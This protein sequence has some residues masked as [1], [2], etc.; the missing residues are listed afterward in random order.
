MG[1][2]D[3]RIFSR[4]DQFF[5]EWVGFELLRSPEDV[6][7]SARS[8][9]QMLTGASRLA[10]GMRKPIKAAHLARNRP[11]GVRETFSYVE[12]TAFMRGSATILVTASDGSRMV[13]RPAD[14]VPEWTGLALN[15]AVVAKALRL[16]GSG[17]G[18]W[19]SIYRLFEVIADDLG[20]IEKIDALGW[21][22]KA[23]LKNFKHTADSVGAVG[24]DARHGTERTQPPTN[25][26]KL[27]HAKAMVNLLLHEWLR[28]KI[29]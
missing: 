29:T 14:A 24:D 4:R 1:A 21:G 23:A 22:R 18:D 20:G 28:S 11:D 8:L 5:L 7:D 26:M 10:L 17:I 9:L 27:A 13:T 25:P 19:V 15:N 3:I 12:E 16:V 2:G 6:H